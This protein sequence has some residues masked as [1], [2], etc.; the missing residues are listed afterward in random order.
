MATFLVKKCRGCKEE[1]SIPLQKRRRKFCTLLCWRKFN[2]GENNSRWSGGFLSNG[3][4]RVHMQDHPF[5]NASGTVLQHRLVMEKKL[6]RYLTENEHVHHINGIRDDNRL[7]NLVIL[8]KSEHIRFHNKGRTPWNKGTH[9]IC[10][11]WNK[12]P[13]IPRPCS[14]CS[15]QFHGG[16]NHWRQKYCSKSCAMKKRWMPSQRSNLGHEQSPPTP[17]PE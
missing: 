12:K 1:F 2:R 3:Y 6:G 16:K 14:Y 11:A 7:S 10:V 17:A 13:K 5:K 8:T 4:I 15:K 9:G